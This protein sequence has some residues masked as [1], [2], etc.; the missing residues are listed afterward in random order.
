MDRHQERFRPDPEELQRVRRFAAQVIAGWNLD[1]GDAVLIANELASNAV[2]HA[3]SDF[4]V[5]FMRSPD[6]V[7]IE[8]QDENPRLPI[9]SPATDGALSGRGLDV[10]EHLSEAWGV[11]SHP[12]DG[13][14][15]WARFR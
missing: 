9:A 15:V 4:V 6:S 10:V 5:A 7:C 8:V 14:T 2:L 11:A 13:K 12:G 3:R 1:S